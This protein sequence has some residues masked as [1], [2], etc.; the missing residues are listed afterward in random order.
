MQ[1]KDTRSLP[2]ELTEQE[3]Q[4]IAWKMARIDESIDETEE[5]QKR[6]SG[7]YKSKVASMQ[8]QKNVYRRT[9]LDKKEYRDVECSIEFDY[10]HQEVITTRDDTDE[11]IERRTMTKD[12]LQLELP[13]TPGRSRKKAA[14]ENERTIEEEVS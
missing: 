5:E 9:V 2:V 1:Q 14:R 3:L 6:V 11:E 13:A 4:A 8:A 7:G 12:E 10:G